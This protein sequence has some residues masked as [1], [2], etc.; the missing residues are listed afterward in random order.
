M[1]FK[2]KF[3]VLGRGI[4]RIGNKACAKVERMVARGFPGAVQAAMDSPSIIGG[5]GEGTRSIPLVNPDP[6]VPVIYQ[7]ASKPQVRRKFWS[8]ISRFKESV[9]GK[10]GALDAVEARRELPGARG[11]G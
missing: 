4:A 3:S 1:Q 6:V 9:K 7:K 2:L 8:K 5:H 11:E 10:G